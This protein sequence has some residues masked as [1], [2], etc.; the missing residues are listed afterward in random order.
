MLREDFNRAGALVCR[1]ALK[2][3]AADAPHLAIV[4]RPAL[5]ICTLDRHLFEAAAEI[6]IPAFTL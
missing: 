4:E 3:R 5:E 1:E 6:G 2:L